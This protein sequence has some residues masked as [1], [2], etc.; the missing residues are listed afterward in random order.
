MPQYRAGTIDHRLAQVGNLLVGI[1]DPAPG[2]VQ[3]TIGRIYG[4][5]SLLTPVCGFVPGDHDRLFPSEALN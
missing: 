5:L 2:A 4:V 3:G 1:C